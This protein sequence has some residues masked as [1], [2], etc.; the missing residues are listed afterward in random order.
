MQYCS[1]DNDCFT[2]NKRSLKFTLIYFLLRDMRVNP[3]MLLKYG[4][5]RLRELTVHP[6]AL[7]VFLQQNSLVYFL[8]WRYNIPI[9]NILTILQ[10]GGVL[11]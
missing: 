7:Y 11:S 10:R 4:H 2:G 8:K 9:T 6:T 1:Y 5:N 3:H